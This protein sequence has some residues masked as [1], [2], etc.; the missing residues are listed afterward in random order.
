MAVVQVSPTHSC[1]AI[2][3]TLYLIAILL[4]R[5]DCIILLNC[6]KTRQICIPVMNGLF[7]LSVCEKQYFKTKKQKNV[8]AFS[9]ARLFCFI[10]STP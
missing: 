5:L 10:A 9:C 3:F 1:T 8:Y 7:I 2:Y 4:N 6:Y